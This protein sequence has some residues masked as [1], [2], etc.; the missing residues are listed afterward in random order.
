MTE[1]QDLMYCTVNV[2]Y[3][4]SDMH[5]LGMSTCFNRYYVKKM[6]IIGKSPVLTICCYQMLI[7]LTHAGNINCT[8]H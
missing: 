1:A 5:L 8:V 7:V 4:H 6:S 3:L 2:A